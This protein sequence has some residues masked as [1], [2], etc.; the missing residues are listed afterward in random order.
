MIFWDGNIKSNIVTVNIKPVIE[1]H[2]LQAKRKGKRK[3][4]VNINR[5]FITIITYKLEASAIMVSVIKIKRCARPKPFE[6]SGSQAI[7]NN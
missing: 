3:R 7:L 6:L 5:F 2:L 4:T 1:T